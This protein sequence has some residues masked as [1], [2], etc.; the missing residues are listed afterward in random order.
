[1]TVTVPPLC[2]AGDEAVPWRGSSPGPRSAA[3]GVVILCRVV[4]LRRSAPASWRRTRE[5]RARTEQ[6]QGQ[7]G[8]SS[9]HRNYLKTANANLPGDLFPAVELGVG[10]RLR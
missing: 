10:Q 5:P 6:G 4:I 2:L 7:V 3:G 8:F 1:M 9:V